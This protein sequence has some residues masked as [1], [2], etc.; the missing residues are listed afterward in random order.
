VLRFG[1]EVTVKVIK[2]DPEQDPHLAVTAGS[3]AGSWEKL[4]Q[5]MRSRRI[6]RDRFTKPR[7]TAPSCRSM[8]GIEGLLHISESRGI[9]SERTEDVLKGREDAAVR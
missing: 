8:A 3:A 6:V 5:S 2:L 1:D 4:V 9:T 7:S